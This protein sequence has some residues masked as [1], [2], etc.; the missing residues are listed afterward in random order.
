MISET[1]P[2]LELRLNVIVSLAKS[3]GDRLVSLDKRMIATYAAGAVSGP[4]LVLLGEHKI[5]ENLQAQLAGLHQGNENGV[6]PSLL[7]ALDANL[8]EPV[9]LDLAY[10]ADH[11]D[12]YYAFYEVVDHQLQ[13]IDTFVDRDGTF[14]AKTM[15][16]R[17]ILF[18][19]AKTA[20]GDTP[21]PDGYLLAAPNPFNATITMTI[22][23][24]RA[25]VGR[26]TIYNLLGRQIYSTGKRELVAGTNS[27]RWHAIN[28]SGI[29]VPS[30]IY[31]IRLETDSGL[32]ALKKV[33]LLK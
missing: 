6:G 2:E 22:D 21:L 31:F 28:N 9:T 10:K 12:A 24:K 20:A 25:D 17:D 13:P 3:A 18:A 8:A 32:T 16:G 33:T 15:T 4:G 27:F 7:Y 11:T 14:T 23:L 29:T 5:P 19:A 26:L 1:R 30:G